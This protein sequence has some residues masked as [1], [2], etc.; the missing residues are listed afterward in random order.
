VAVQDQEEE[1]PYA[2]EI[3]LHLLRYYNI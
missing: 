3:N 1:E 2:K